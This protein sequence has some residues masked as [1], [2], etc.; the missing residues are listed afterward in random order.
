[1]T[2]IQKFLE[3]KPIFSH[4]QQYKVLS[5]EIGA[6]AGDLGKKTSPNFTSELVVL[7]RRMKP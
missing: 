7:I 3:G 1:M 4:L 6:I 2:E 5:S